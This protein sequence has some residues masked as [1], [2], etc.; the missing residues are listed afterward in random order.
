MLAAVRKRGISIEEVR[1]VKPVGRTLHLTQP[2]AARVEGVKS[3]D[4]YRNEEVPLREA[5]D[6]SAYDAALYTC[7]SSVRRIAARSVG[8]APAVAIGRRTAAALKEAGAANV[9]VAE[10]ATIDDL[11]AAAVRA[12]PRFP[13]ACR[14]GR[15]SC[16][17]GRHRA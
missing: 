1:E 13:L 6:L 14:S 2:D 8:D 17:P 9:I 12:I 5:V 16:P 3:I 7:A 10:S 11:V 4:V 15:P